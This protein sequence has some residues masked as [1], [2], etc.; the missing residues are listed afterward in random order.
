MRFLNRSAEHLPLNEK[1]AERMGEVAAL[2]A[3]I[4]LNDIPTD[5]ISNM[6]T[7]SRKEEVRKD[8]IYNCLRAY[9]ESMGEAEKASE[10]DAI[11]QCKKEFLEKTNVFFEPKVTT[12]RFLTRLGPGA[13]EQFDLETRI[14]LRHAQCTQSRRIAPWAD[15]DQF[16]EPTTSPGREWQPLQNKFM[17]EVLET[18]PGDAQ[19]GGLRKMTAVTGHLAKYLRKVQDAT[20]IIVEKGPVDDD[21]E[22]P[23]RLEI[24]REHVNQFP[25]L[26]LPRDLMVP[27]R[28]SSH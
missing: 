2:G 14:F 6:R 3:C 11:V 16:P 12:V 18:K 8:D 21:S 5:N 17:Q 25:L 27:N 23:S 20:K 24:L 15:F 4:G 9:E 10:S 22:R 13:E 7:H 19:T 28:T 1:V 26:S